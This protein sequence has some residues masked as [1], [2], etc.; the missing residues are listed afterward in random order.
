[1]SALVKAL[2]AQLEARLIETHIS[3]VLLAGDT[4]WKI[5][6]PV[7]LPF[8][9]YGS[10]AARRRC[11]EEELRL[12]R[13]LAPG[14]YLDVVPIT[15]SAAQPRLGGDGPALDYALRMRRFADGALFSELLPAG[16][17]QAGEVDELARL[18][19]DFHS[20][21]AAA[22]PQ[23]GFGTPQRRRDLGAGRLRRRR[24]GA[25]GGPV[26]TCTAGCRSRRTPCSRCGRHGSPRDACARATATCTWPTWCGWTAA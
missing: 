17:L 5:K 20:Q 3:W 11:C 8:V 1:M 21:A 14:L 2:A 10:L 6:K 22:A 16:A 13:R 15:G 19:A 18:L 4:A 25:A 12:N 26:A 9:D 7:T 23:D 24:R